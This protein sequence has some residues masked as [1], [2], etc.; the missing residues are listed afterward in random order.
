MDRNNVLDVAGRVEKTMGNR[1]RRGIGRTEQNWNCLTYVPHDSASKENVGGRWE[2][3]GTCITPF[4]KCFR[5]DESNKHGEHGRNEHA[6]ELLTN[7]DKGRQVS[8]DVGVVNQSIIRM[9]KRRR[10]RSEVGVYIAEVE[11]EDFRNSN[12]FMDTT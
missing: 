8:E 5:T 1:R 10:R 12:V 3:R 2:I 11:N 6:K 9:K 7:V 4:A